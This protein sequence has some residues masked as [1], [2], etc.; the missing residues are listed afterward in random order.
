MC[1]LK[2]KYLFE[3]DRVFTLSGFLTILAFEISWKFYFGLKIGMLK[4]VGKNARHFKPWSSF[5]YLHKASLINEYI[6]SHFNILCLVLP[7]G[8]DKWNSHIACHLSSVL[9]SHHITF[10]WGPPPLLPSNL[11]LMIQC[12]MQWYSVM[13]VNL[14]FVCL[15]NEIV[16][17]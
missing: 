17:A 13:H 3:I 11:V 9:V 8:L 16:T 7:K 2:S 15:I 10:L 4:K 1:P 14:K 12:T 6:T 5:A